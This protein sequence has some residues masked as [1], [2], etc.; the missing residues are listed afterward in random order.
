MASRLGL[1]LKRLNTALLR[2]LMTRLQAH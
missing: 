1:T 2:Q